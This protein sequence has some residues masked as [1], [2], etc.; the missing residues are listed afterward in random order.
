M[1]EERTRIVEGK[2]EKTLLELH[3]KK[4]PLPKWGIANWFGFCGQ[5]FITAEVK[6]YTGKNIVY[7]VYKNT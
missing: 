4:R 6:L 7:K 1:G 5:F 2:M 3:R